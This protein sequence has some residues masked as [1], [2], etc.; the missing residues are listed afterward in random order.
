[1]NHPFKMVGL[2]W[3]LICTISAVKAEQIPKFPSVE[4]QV[5]QEVEPQVLPQLK[6]IIQEGET[7][8]NLDDVRND[9]LKDATLIELHDSS[10]FEI[11]EHNSYWFNLRISNT[12]NSDP[13]GLSFLRSGDCWPWEFTFKTIESFSIDNLGTVSKGFSGTTVSS[14]QR[15]Y[16][17]H[18][19]TSMIR[20]NIPKNAVK[21]IWV[22]LSMAQ[23]CN[24]KV[25]LELRS[26]A[27]INA[28]KTWNLM[29]AF[30][31]L[32]FGAIIA[33]FFLALFLYIW[34][35]ENVYL[36]FLIFQLI[37][38]FSSFTYEYRD[39][40]IYYFFYHNPRQFVITATFLD[41]IKFVSLIQFGRVYIGTDTKFPRLHFLLGFSIFLL[42]FIALGGAITRS[43]P[44][45]PTQL[46]FAI[47]PTLLRITL[48]TI[49][50][51]F[52]LLIFS[53]DRFAQYFCI[54]AIFPYGS[55]LI[56]LLSN[57]VERTFIY[58]YLIINSGIVITMTLVLAYRFKVISN[59]RE[60]A[61]E[62]KLTAESERLHQLEQINIASNKFVPQ[63][64]LNFLGKKNI[65]DATLGDY[66]EKQV[67]V[68]FSDIRDFTT[69]SENMTP[70]ENF[71]FVNAYNQQMAPVIQN[72]HGFI[73]QFL[74]DGFMAIFP[75]NT[76]ETLQ[77]AIVMLQKLEKFNQQRF[78]KNQSL[79][80]MGIGIHAGP[81]VMG[82]I[83]DSQRMD[84][85][86]ISDTVNVASR[87]ENLTKHFGVPLLLS[88]ET[89]QKIGNKN[90]FHF[91]YLGEILVKGKRAPVGIYECFDGETKEQFDF[92]IVTLALFKKG[93]KQYFD[94][95][96]E[97]A[98]FTFN[99]VLEKNPHD[100]PAHLF[101][102]K[103]KKFAN[104]HI[105]DHW[106]GVESIEKK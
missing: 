51:V 32:M 50:G 30:Y 5:Q 14:S 39:E 100:A 95:N 103:A 45:V 40:M 8:L 78:S 65:L 72:H 73:N 10:F 85:A 92:K 44:E 1:M 29:S 64:F 43:F 96:F 89:F 66:V 28:P 58:T 63:T 90:K 69:L 105:G 49:V 75:E 34:S 17:K 79:I 37:L 67:S 47:R 15:D 74:G 12:I 76:E 84:A 20:I 88:E 86:T 27:L 38:L 70:K 16:P 42:F 2:L 6:W 56:A 77:A 18:F 35:K 59:Q 52:L 80:R 91:R 104:Q 54:G 26:D 31:N 99:S 87:I 36:W 62:E 19:K 13:M 57:S 98:I 53:K 3:I 23:V 81:L 93:L 22:K 41:V 25:N 82:I 71:Q 33:F 7:P 94:K 101:L 61:I 48:M 9:N 55:L 11:I 68:L 83:G 60:E 4:Y 106:S 21:D 24:I 97:A 102:L 46:W